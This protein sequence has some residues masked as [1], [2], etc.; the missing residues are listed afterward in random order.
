[1]TKL[2]AK[3]REILR[4]SGVESLPND[5]SARG[6][7][8]SEI[9]KRM[10][11]PSSLVFDWLARLIKEVD[12]DFGK[13]PYF[14]KSL[15]EAKQYDLSSGD[16]VVVYGEDFG[17][18]VA[19][20]SGGVKTFNQ[21]GYSLASTKTLLDSLSTRL[22]E[23]IAK[24]EEETQSLVD[25]SLIV[26]KAVKAAKD[27]EG[28]DIVATY[29]TKAESTA[30]DEAIRRDVEQGVLIAKKALMDGNGNTIFETYETKADSANKFSSIASGA[31]IVGKA[32]KDAN[33]NVI[34]S[35][36]VPVSSIVN[37]L[38]STSA[39]SP[40]SAM[41]GKQL[42]A[43]IEHIYTLLGSDDAS[44]D[45][46]QE[47]VDY[48]KNHSSVLEAITISKA[49]I[50]DLE[51]GAIVVGKSIADE[52]G[53]DIQLTYSTIDSLTSGSLQVAKAIDSV[54]AVNATN[55]A[56]GRKIDETYAPLSSISGVSLTA[57]EVDVI[58]KSI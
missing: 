38:T 4:L 50:S 45:T 7:N 35:Y 56:L 26:G 47:V 29:E 37:N 5:P 1:M 20:V 55:D 12:E 19:N 11:A 22:S 49:S 6:F 44:L 8:A 27:N 52:A 15:E 41:Q 25:G 40:L 36:Y 28:N 48:I 53:N 30:K 57:S 33:G 9:K 10:S 54:N 42:N 21:I 17:V 3:E 23:A 31:T 2:T 16:V 13:F 34:T 58:Y 51:N 18:Y 43:K 46:L 32:L 24:H 39:T 14:A